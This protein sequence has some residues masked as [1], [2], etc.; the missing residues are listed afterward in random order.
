M[1]PPTTPRP[2]PRIV[3]VDTIG[4]SVRQQLLL[5]RA[6]LAPEH[7]PL[8]QR[9]PGAAWSSSS[10]RP[11]R[12]ARGPGCRRRAAGARRSAMRSNRRSAPST[13]RAAD[14]AEVGRAA[15]DV[16]HQDQRA[17]AEQLRASVAAMR[18]NPRVQRGQ[19]LFE[20]RQAGRDPASRAACTVSS[21]ASSSNEAGTVRTIVLPFEAQRCRLGS[22]T[23]VVPGVA[24]MSEE[25]RRGVDGRQL[26]AR[27]QAPQGRN[28]RRAIDRRIRRATTSPTR[29]AAPA[30]ARPD[31]ARTR[32]PRSSGVSRPT[33]GA[34]A[35]RRCSA[36]VGEI[37]ERRQRRAAARSRPRRR[38][39]ARRRCA[40]RLGVRRPRR[41][42]SWWCRDRCRSSS[43]P[44]DGSVGSRSRMFSSSFH[45]ERRAALAGATR[46]SLHAPQLERA[47]LGH[48]ALERD[49]HRRSFLSPSTGSVT[50]SGAQSPRGR[51]P[52][53]R[54]ARRPGRPS[55]SSSSGTGTPPARRRPART[56]RFGIA[57][58]VPSSMPNGTTQSALSGAGMPGTAGIALSM[59]T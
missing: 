41:A 6:A 39:A 58:L 24:Q 7:V 4:G 14:Q 51:R 22:A 23:L 37:E 19:R 59:P 5:C 40:R 52:S 2:A 9:E 12:R 29:S 43:S 49:R 35:R 47:D 18:R 45:R 3:I 33:A 36:A 42:P 30:P 38:A 11:A 16:A 32:R 26:R 44:S 54:S 55:G 21:R 10:A 1:P 25:A 17:G 56:R 50:S 13:R 53:P 15:A 46:R 31:R 57:A 34:P 8:R 20:Q 48:P 27:R 28:A